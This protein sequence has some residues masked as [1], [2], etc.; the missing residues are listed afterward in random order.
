MKRLISLMLGIVLSLSLCSFGDYITIDS[1]LSDWAGI[2]YTDQG[3]K[4]GPDGGSYSLRTTYDSQNLY[5]A[6][7]RSSTGRILGDTGTNYDDTSYSPDDSF[8][9]AFDVD[10]I[11]DS[12]GSSNVTLANGETDGMSIS[13]GGDNLPDIIYAFSGGGNWFTYST[14]NGSEWTG[15]A[16]NWVE[17]EDSSIGVSYGDSGNDGDEFAIPLQDIGSPSGDIMAWA[18]MAK[19]SHYY[20]EAAW[21]F[22]S[23]AQPTAYDGMSVAVPEPFTL[24]LLGIGSIA[25]RRRRKS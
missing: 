8:F 4:S 18:W 25:L 24:G 17:P 19:E 3:T 9:L 12:G 20:I 21:G 10:G 16:D 5:I 7:D 14:W 6:V 23:G 15:D 11:T 2:D 1:D 13:F 22:S